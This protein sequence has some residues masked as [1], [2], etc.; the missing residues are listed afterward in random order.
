MGKILGIAI[1]LAAI[2]LVAVSAV[3]L[4]NSTL[5]SRV[6]FLIALGAAG[7]VLTPIGL[8]RLVP[9]RHLA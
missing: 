1:I 8:R 4:F 9:C 6:A 5:D 2:G 7:L 3:G